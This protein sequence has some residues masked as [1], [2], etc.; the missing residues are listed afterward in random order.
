MHGVQEADV[1]AFWEAMIAAVMK[2]DMV[3]PLNSPKN[4]V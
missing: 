4:P 2:A 3:S 1:P